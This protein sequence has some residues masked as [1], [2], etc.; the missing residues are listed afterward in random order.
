MCSR[1]L[2]PSM[3][4]MCTSESTMSKS[5]LRSRRVFSAS[6]PRE[7]VV[8]ALLSRK[9]GGAREKVGSIEGCRGGEAAGIEDESSD[10]R[11]GRRATYLANPRV[12][13][14]GAVSGRM[15]SRVV[16]AVAVSAPR[17]TGEFAFHLLVNGTHVRSGTPTFV[18]ASL[19]HLLD[20]LQ[21]ER[22]I[23]DHENPQA[24]GE[25]LRLHRR[26]HGDGTRVE[27]RG[28]RRI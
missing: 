6:A 15:R 17:P 21:A 3:S 14:F 13:P 25:P 2:K 1:S 26:R 9:V 22:V 11:A 4:G 19:Q 18:L 5:S 24:D 10:E 12:H 7:K 16:H 23:V 28:A 8:T 27:R 20:N